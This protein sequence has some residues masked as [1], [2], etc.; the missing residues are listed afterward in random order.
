MCRTMVLAH[1]SPVTIASASD[2][3]IAK[4]IVPYETFVLMAVRFL[5]LKAIAVAV[6]PTM[7]ITMFCTMLPKS[8]KAT[9]CTFV[10]IGR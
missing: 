2:A 6:M 10:C 1:K 4:A 8:D 3:N 7:A 5:L 9:A